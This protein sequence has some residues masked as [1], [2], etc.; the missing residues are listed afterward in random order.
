MADLVLGLAKTA[1]EGTITIAKSAIEEDEYLKTTV[2]RDL[3]LI[4]DE[5]E[6]M[7]SFLSVARE[8]VIDNVSRTAVRQVRDLALDVEDC[9][10]FVIALGDRS[11][12]WRRM[13][14]PCLPA[15]ARIS[16]LDEAVADIELLK[17]RVEAMGQ[18]NLRYYNNFSSSRAADNP[19]YHDAVVNA[20]AMDI[21]VDA[22][23]TAREE[24]RRPVDLVQLIRR[25]N[26]VLELQVL[27]VWGTTGNL[28]TTRVI[29]KAYDDAKI[30]QN[31]RLRAWVKLTLPFNRSEFIRSLLTQ[32]YTDYYCPQKGSTAT[33][34]VVLKPV[35]VMVLTEDRVVNKFVEIT[36]IH[37]FLIV[38]EDV[39][40]MAEWEAI[41]PLLPDSKNGSC[42][43]VH[44]QGLEV[45]SLSVGRAYSVLELEQC[46]DDHSICV[47]LKEDKEKDLQATKKKAAHVWLHKFDNIRV[48][49]EIDINTFH[50]MALDSKDR[51]ALFVWGVFGVGKTSVVKHVYYKEFG[52]VNVSHPFNLRDLSW[53]LLLDLSTESLQHNSVLG[54]KD[55]IQECRDLLYEH[56]CLVVIH[57]MES[58]EDWFLTKAYLGIEH[59]KS[60]IIVITNEENVATQCAMRSNSLFNIKVLEVDEAKS[61]FEKKVKDGTSSTLEL[62]RETELTTIIDKCGGL[63]KEGRN[64]LLD[65]E[66]W[67]MLWELNR[68]FMHELETNQA[69]SS[70]QGLFAWVNSYFRNCPDFLKPCIFYLSIFPVNH[71]I[72]RRRLV[73][74]WVAEGY[75]RDTKESTAE[76]NAEEFFSQLVKLSMIQ[77]LGSTTAMEFNIKMP[78]CHVNSF[79][80]EYIISRSMEENVVFSL[81]G[82]CHLNPQ[83]TG[84]HLVIGRTWDRDRNVFESIDLS[85]LRSLTVFGEWRSFFISDR[86]R[87]LRVL[88]LDDTSGVE[89]KDLELIV[90]AVPR[91]K[92]LSL[93]GCKEISY[94]PNSLGGLRQLQSLDIRGTSIVRLPKSITKL[95]KL[96]YIRAGTAAPCDDDT[97]AVERPREPAET[98]SLF[99]LLMSRIEFCRCCRSSDSCSHGVEVPGGIGKL[100]ALHT[101]GVIDISVTRG[102]AVLKALKNLTQLHKIGVSGINKN[103]SKGFFDAISDHGHL[104]SLS[105]QLDEGNPD[106]LDPNFVVPDSLRSLKLYGQVCLPSEWIDRLGNLRK[107]KLETETALPR[108]KIDIVGELP[109]LAILTLSFKKFEN[110]ELHFGTQFCQLH[111]LEI[112]C[113]SELKSVKFTPS[114]L[115]S[116]EALKLH[117]NGDL[118]SDHLQ[119]SGLANLG[120]LK[121]V[122]LHG[123]YNDALEQH[124]QDELARHPNEIKPVL[125]KGAHSS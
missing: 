16:E 116:L 60:R 108:E 84:R 69:F 72:R 125:R 61:L 14:P 33:D 67:S 71:K 119:F 120:E 27:S 45:A 105:V 99:T 36:N 10:E 32:F 118:D 62:T 94:L 9:I 70:L 58:T 19:I 73:R 113:C 17:A 48:G 83:V 18:R 107:L 74:R 106:C 5:F 81:E 115:P 47:F 26:S 104:E 79:F 91:L 23:E 109:K 3:R 38:L 80:R 41:R 78:L 52:W 103:N 22:R 55:P 57:G 29:R 12:W 122:W 49:R 68:N 85:R 39:H 37:R 93:R 110:H 11:N 2:K 114:G 20:T 124:L 59:S 89:H 44:T 88:D 96:Q 121:E 100:I 101:I 4:S 35:E 82:R 111:L 112:G 86:M 66:E 7:H 95:L 64:G 56:K 65:S 123:S 28:W 92:F 15:A 40:T 34:Y 54:I 90:T 1:L 87:L 77:L 50:H 51:G 31:F 25:N 102:Q 75:S 6:M 24:R 76:E 13:I 117:C 46:Y 42:I 98:P 43:I 21:L 53:S 8:R 63:P 30:C 97:N